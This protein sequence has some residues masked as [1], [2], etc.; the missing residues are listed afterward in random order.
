MKIIIKN[1]DGVIEKEIPAD[2]SKTLLKQLEEAGLEMQSAC[3]AGICGACICMID[4]GFESIDKSFSWE[5][6]FPLGD[7]E[8]MTCIAWVSGNGEGDI[9]LRKI[10]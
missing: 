3:H 2:L 1:I 4:G 7:D 6:G 9:V 10:Y 8:V 5:P